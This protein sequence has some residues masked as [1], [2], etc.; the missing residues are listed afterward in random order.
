MGRRGP[1]PTPTAILKLRGSSRA[2]GRA[3]PA[4]EA[5][6]PPA[7]AFLCKVARAEYERAGALLVAARVMTAA[8][9]AVLTCYSIAWADWLAARAE[10]D[11][12]GQTYTTNTGYV[13]PSPWVAIAKGARETMLRA[14]AELGLTPASRAR[15]TTI[16]RT[17]EPK[18]DAEA[19][20][21]TARF[22]GA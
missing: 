16:G 18:P 13:R 4:I 15:V 7:P 20:S 5:E 11:T 1:K 3:A 17:Q 8:D 9:L 14:A 6:L 12:H 21:K 19:Q 22:F 10:I 2:N